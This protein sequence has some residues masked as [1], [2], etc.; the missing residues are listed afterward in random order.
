MTLKAFNLAILAGWLL[1]LIGGC[2][3]NLGAGLIGG[4]LLLLVLTF[5]VSRLAGIYSPPENSKENA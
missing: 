1:V 3:L 5:A 4:G 2:L